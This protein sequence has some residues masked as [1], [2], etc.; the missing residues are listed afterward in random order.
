MAC[1][2]VYCI[3]NKFPEIDCDAGTVV[4]F[5]YGL[6]G[7]LLGWGV[8]LLAFSWAMT[9]FVFIVK[10]L[11]DVYGGEKPKIT[12]GDIA[13]KEAGTIVGLAIITAVS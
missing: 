13:E 5:I 4:H 9:T 7:I 3:R 6:L 1:D 10:Q 12:G 2:I 11:L 8:G